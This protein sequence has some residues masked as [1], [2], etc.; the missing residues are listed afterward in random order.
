M[1]IVELKPDPVIDSA[2]KPE[3]LSGNHTSQ[4]W[5]NISNMCN[6]VSPQHS[7]ICSTPNEIYGPSSTRNVIQEQISCSSSNSAL[8][9]RKKSVLGITRCRFLTIPQRQVRA[10][11]RSYFGT[12][13]GCI[14]RFICIFIQRT[15]VVTNNLL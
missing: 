9:N 14:V 7:Q 10:G 13:I 11:A 4:S 1:K 2:T 15:Y 3:T 8:G 5:L 12:G 6:A